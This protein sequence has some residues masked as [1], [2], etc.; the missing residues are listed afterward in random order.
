MTIGRSG[1]ERQTAHRRAFRCRVQAPWPRQ[2]AAAAGAGRCHLAAGAGAERFRAAGSKCA[3]CTPGRPRARDTAVAS[4]EA[5]RCRRGCGRNRRVPA[6]NRRKKTHLPEAPGSASGA[7]PAGRGNRH[8]AHAGPE[9]A[10][11]SGPGQEEERVT[12][13]FVTILATQSKHDHGE[14][15][16]V[17]I[18]LHLAVAA[19]CRDLADDLSCARRLRRAP[20][21]SARR[22]GAPRARAVR[23]SGRSKTNAAPR[24]R[25][26]RHRPAPGSRRSRGAGISP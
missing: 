23:S 5:A 4:H 3:P 25:A 16:Q 14:K 22:D 26:S 24:P 11:A 21:R 8:A 2:I 12:A 1:R 9:L 7:Q 20:R 13:Q 18:G 10:E 15:Q 19:Q 6:D 17:D